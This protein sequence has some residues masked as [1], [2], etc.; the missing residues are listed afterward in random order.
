MTPLRNDAP[1]LG[2]CIGCLHPPFSLR[3]KIRATTNNDRKCLL[4]GP[5]LKVQSKYQVACYEMYFCTSPKRSARICSKLNKT[6]LTGYSEHNK[7]NK[8]DILAYDS[9]SGSFFGLL[10][11]FRP[12][13]GR[14]RLGC[15]TNIVRAITTRWV[16]G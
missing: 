15:R 8:L 2:V 7:C 5:I 3:S 16:G 6:V 11:L 9:T 1:R 10:N 4:L 13:V 12:H 14:K